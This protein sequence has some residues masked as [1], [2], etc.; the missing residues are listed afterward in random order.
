MTE[1]FQANETTGTP[2]QI[3]AAIALRV[4][5]ETPEPWTL[6]DYAAHLILVAALGLA[7]F[8]MVIAVVQIVGT[9]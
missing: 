9:K 7:T 8:A 4:A 6:L 2:Q 3:A 1:R 5:Y